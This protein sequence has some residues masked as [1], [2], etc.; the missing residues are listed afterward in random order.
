MPN[1][2]SDCDLIINKPFFSRHLQSKHKSISKEKTIQLKRD[3]YEFKKFAIENN[4]LLYTK[5]QLHLAFMPK[6]I[7]VEFLNLLNEHLHVRGMPPQVRFHLYL[8][9]LLNFSHKCTLFG[10][11]YQLRIRSQSKYNKCASTTTM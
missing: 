9:K 6:Y 2:C 5:M 7:Q 11:I 1:Y 3:N 10:R 4:L 8:L